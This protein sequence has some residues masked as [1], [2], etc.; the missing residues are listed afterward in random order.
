MIKVLVVDEQNLTH[1]I[2]E[3]YLQSETEIT[4]IGFANNA[5]E[6]IEQ[7]SHLQ[8]DVILMDVETPKIDDLAPTKFITQKFPQ[9]KVL[10]LTVHDH[11]QDLREALKN[12][13]KGYLLKNIASQELKNAI[14]YANQGYFQLSLELTEKYLQNIILTKSESEEIS[15]IKSQLKFLDKFYSKLEEKLEKCQ[16]GS[17]EEQIERK[18][19]GILQKEMAFIGDRDSNLQFKVDR[20]K[21]NQERLEQNVKYLSKVQTGCAIIVLLAIAYTIFSSFN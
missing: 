17:S 13:A 20:L 3:N 16:T 9:T 7:I 1:R 18:I 21:Y 15:E 10:I 4:I 12:G 5:Q 19:A 11:E 2:I 8:P 6:A 14:Y